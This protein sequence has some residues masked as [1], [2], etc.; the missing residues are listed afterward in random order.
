MAPWPVDD[1]LPENLTWLTELAVDES[2][3]LGVSIHSG[4]VPRRDSRWG[5]WTLLRPLYRR[6]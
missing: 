2:L 3:D 6:E 5:D 4:L 1:D